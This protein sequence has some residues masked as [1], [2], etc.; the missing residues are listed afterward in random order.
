MQSALVCHGATPW[1]CDPCLTVNVDM[2]TVVHLICSDVQR[3]RLRRTLQPLADTNAGTF[4]VECE[5]SVTMGDG[6]T[7]DPQTQ[8]ASDTAP[9][10]HSPTHCTGVA[11]GDA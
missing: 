5:E 6:T 4:L 3:I 2:Y 11:N 10:S 9:L 8:W 7:S 1:P